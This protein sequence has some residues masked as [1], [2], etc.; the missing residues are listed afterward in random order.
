MI[1]GG[2]MWRTDNMDAPCAAPAGVADGVYQFTET[3]DGYTLFWFCDL[4]TF[5][6]MMDKRR[7]QYVFRAEGGQ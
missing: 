6:K 5:D 3:A 2:K 1:Q 7:G 4:A